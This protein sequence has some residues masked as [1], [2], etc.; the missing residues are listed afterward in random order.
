M[1]EPATSS[2]AL[3]EIL[4]LSLLSIYDK[5]DVSGTRKRRHG[6]IKRLGGRRIEKLYGESK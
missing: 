5:Y 4:A 3:R 2:M 6:L 1:M